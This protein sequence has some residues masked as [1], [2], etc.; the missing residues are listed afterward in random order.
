[1]VVYEG[2]G[3][4]FPCSALVYTRDKGPAQ[5]T[6]PSQIYIYSIGLKLIIADVRSLHSKG[7]T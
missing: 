2:H 3:G 6:L 1:M 7:R 5:L 4:L